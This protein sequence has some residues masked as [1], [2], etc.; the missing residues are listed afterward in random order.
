[1]KG[2]FLTTEVIVEWLE[3]ID[4]VNST[5]QGAAFQN[6][7]ACAC[8]FTTYCLSTLANQSTTQKTHWF[9]A[10]SLARLEKA[11]SEIQ[12]LLFL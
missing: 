9:A 5:R 4:Y 10:V 2:Q 6:C 1:M 12:N 3:G 11:R 8:A 7:G